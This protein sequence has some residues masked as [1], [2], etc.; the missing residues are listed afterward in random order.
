MRLQK[1]QVHRLGPDADVG[2]QFSVGGVDAYLSRDLPDG[3]ADMGRG[4]KVA[5][6]KGQVQTYMSNRILEP[7]DEDVYPDPAAIDDAKDGFEDLP[8]WST[9]TPAEALAWVDENV[10]DLATAKMVLGKLTQAVLYL[11]DIVI[12]K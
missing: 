9:W 7:R 1:V 4:D 10:T 11:R 5:W 3:W 2:I 8:G 6:V 12:E